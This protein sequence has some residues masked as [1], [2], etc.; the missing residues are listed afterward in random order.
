MSR[1]PPYKLLIMNME[2]NIQEGRREYMPSDKAL[3]LLK[4]LTGQDFGDDIEAWKKWLKDNK[5][6]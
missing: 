4:S 3:E 1:I 6:H 2:H 5:K